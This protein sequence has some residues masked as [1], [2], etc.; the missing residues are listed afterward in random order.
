M[1]AAASL[2]ASASDE[3]AVQALKAFVAADPKRAQR[4]LEQVHDQS[5]ANDSAA[6]SRAAGPG[7]APTVSAGGAAPDA[8]AGAVLPPPTPSA[9]ESGATSKPAAP[10][11]AAAPK[12]T[13]QQLVL[14]EHNF[15]R[16]FPQRYAARRVRPLLPLFQ[17]KRVS[18]D[19]SSVLV[20]QEGAAPVLELLQ[21]LATL[22]P[23]PPLELRS[24][25]C[26]AATAHALDVGLH[27][28]M[29]HEGS[30]GSDVQARLERFGEW[31][32]SVGESLSFGTHDA[33]DVVLWLLIDDGVAD[34]GHR[35]NALDP[36]MRCLGCSPVAPHSK[37]R[38]CAVV[39]YA[40][41]F[42][43]RKPSL[44]VKLQANAQG[45]PNDNFIAILASLPHGLAELKAEIEKL[46]FPGGPRV[47][48]DFRPGSLEIKVTTEAK[49]EIST[50]TQR[51]TWTVSPAAA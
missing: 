50:T 18:L 3:E 11:A 21:L 15:V 36:A 23:R 40:E 34:R 46:L 38:H 27:G 13:F 20:T 9:P 33:T 37:L 43:P 31:W 6:A 8:A 22:S 41:G 25:L 51:A 45:A 48:L 44:E 24:G 17:G 1:G 35:D 32:G 2:L 42:G 30:D 29:S 14:E 5:T 10:R 28:S 47:H 7:G 39:E 4:L 26:S 12:A 19:T 16:Q 49:G